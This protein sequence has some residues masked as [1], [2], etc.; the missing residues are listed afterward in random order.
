[1]YP[2]F[3][4]TYAGVSEP[5]GHWCPRDP[6]RPDLIPN[7]FNALLQNEATLWDS[8]AASGGLQA[9]CRAKIYTSPPWVTPPDG[10]KRIN[11]VGAIALPSPNDL[12]TLIWSYEMPEGYDGCLT[13]VMC[14]YNG[15][16]GG[17]FVEGSTDLN[18]RF[19]CNAFWL[20]GFGNI[21]TQLG[22]TQDPW[23]NDSGTIILQSGQNIRAW[24]NRSSAS[25][26]TIV[27]G[28]IIA[29]MFGWRWPR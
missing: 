26:G 25:A 18:W 24:V 7:R 10:A 22:S 5:V 2:N 9:C 1:M 15:G 23:S 3:Y 8:I 14:I 11:Q 4:P 21:Q 6:K 29:G 20:D 16:T 13:G 27:G 12:D 17:V 28:N 19:S